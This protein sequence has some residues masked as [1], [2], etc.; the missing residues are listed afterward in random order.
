MCGGVWRCGFGFCVLLCVFVCFPCAFEKRREENRKKI[1]EEKRREE[2]KR[3]ERRRREEQRLLFHVPARREGRENR[4]GRT[5]DCT[6]IEVI[7]H[8]ES[9]IFGDAED[10]RG[11]NSFKQFGKAGPTPT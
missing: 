8:E 6:G 4:R 1:R 5:S 10:G 2:K 7:P 11:Q 9:Y 3:E